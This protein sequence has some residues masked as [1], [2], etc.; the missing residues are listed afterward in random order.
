ML[1]WAG[2]RARGR[3]GVRA[4]GG[5]RRG[6][7][8]ALARC[9][10]RCAWRLRPTRSRRAPRR[11]TSTDDLEQLGRYGNLLIGCTDL[12]EALQTSEQMLSLLLPDSA[13][14]DLPADRWRR[15]GRGHAPVGHPRRRHAHAGQ[16]GGMPVHAAPSACTSAAALRRKAV[17]AHVAPA[18]ARISLPPAFRWLTQGESL[19]WLYLSAPATE[20]AQADGRGRGRRP[21]RARA[22]Q[23]QAAP[24]P[25]RPV[26]ARSADRPVQPPLPAPN[27]W[28]AKWRAASGATCRSR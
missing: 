25:A 10:G 9:R 18:T 11:K 22:G 3:G 17:C 19:G 21:A 8:A 26:G 15:P 4:A 20:P 7:A 6:D 13:G 1:P 2:T 23:P 28:A 16:R 27:R 24:E 12:A 5:W 14:S